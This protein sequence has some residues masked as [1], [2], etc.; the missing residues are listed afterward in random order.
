MNQDKEEKSIEE[1]KKQSWQIVK[2]ESQKLFEFLTKNWKPI[3]GV[4]LVLVGFFLAYLETRRLVSQNQAMKLQMAES[5][6]AHVQDM[7]QISA[8]FERQR[9]AQERIET[10]F[11]R[12]IEELN[13]NYQEQL[14]RVSQARRVRQRQ[15]ESNPSQ[16]PETYQTVFGIP[17]RA[18]QD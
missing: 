13:R 8:S 1:P 2:R 9:L 4:A 11:K 7:E 5:R 12:R 14:S 6:A 17:R 15:I 18:E 10:E 3:V 16:L